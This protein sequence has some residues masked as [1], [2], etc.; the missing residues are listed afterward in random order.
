[1]VASLSLISHN[2]E[3][4]SSYPADVL[5]LV[6]AQIGLLHAE[7]RHDMASRLVEFFQ[8]PARR[9][10]WSALQTPQWGERDMKFGTWP[11]FLSS[12]ANPSES[13]TTMMAK[14]V[15]PMGLFHLY[16]CHMMLGCIC[17]NLCC[18]SGGTSMHRQCSF[19]Q[20]AI[21]SLLPFHKP[22]CGTHHPR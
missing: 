1:M 13:C 16:I 6:C 18:S 7:T 14:D 22:G 15:H 10:W 12:P 2:Y 21:Q 8:L 3:E 17:A 20:D 19:I 9:G 4:W 11:T 5:Q